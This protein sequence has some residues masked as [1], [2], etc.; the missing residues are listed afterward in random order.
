MTL[1]IPKKPGIGD[2][3]FVTYKG[4]PNTSTYWELVEVQ[5]AVEATALGSLSKTI[6]LTDSNGFAVNQY[7]ASQN[8]ADAGKTER[9]KV[10]EGA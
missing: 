4:T 8:A 5:G 1:T 10:R 7:F 2:G 3:M 9:I 6:V